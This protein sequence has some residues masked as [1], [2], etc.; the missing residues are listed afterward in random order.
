VLQVVE[1]DVAG[2]HD[3]GRFGIV[4]QREQQVL[5]R[6]VFMMTF[7]GESKRLMKRLFQALGESRHL[8]SPHFFSITHCSG[9]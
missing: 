6:R 2:A 3:C 4:D 5:E 7:V 9:C 8:L 1:V